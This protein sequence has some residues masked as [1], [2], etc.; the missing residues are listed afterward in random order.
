MYTHIHIHILI[1][2]YIHIYIYIC[3]YS[4]VPI[5]N[6]GMH[7]VTSLLFVKDLLLI[8]VLPL[9]CS[10]EREKE[11]ERESYRESEKG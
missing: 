7:N 8:K 9:F 3:T 5:F 10:L 11:R 2:M 1:Y 4:R 6:K